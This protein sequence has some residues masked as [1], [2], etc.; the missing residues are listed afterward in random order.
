MQSQAADT[1]QQAAADLSQPRSVA[2]N[3]N[4]YN[5]A[6]EE[7][8]KWEQVHNNLFRLFFQVGGS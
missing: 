1:G 7:K 6:M 8:H 5:R 4:R 3:Q 2:A